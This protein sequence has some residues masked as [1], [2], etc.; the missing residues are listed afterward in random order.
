MRE[1]GSRAESMGSLQSKAR[2]HR[3]FWLVRRSRGVIMVFDPQGSFEIDCP[4][5]V[6]SA[7]EWQMMRATAVE[8]AARAAITGHARGRLGEWELCALRQP[9]GLRPPGTTTVWLSVLHR[10][11]VLAELVT[12]L[13]DALHA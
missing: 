7:P 6:A 8:F 12:E 2:R 9:T 1:A 10:D 13:P 3:P 11:K 4:G 5:A